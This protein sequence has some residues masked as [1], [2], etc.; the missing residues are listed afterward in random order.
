MKAKDILNKILVELNRK[1]KLAQMTLE[2][3]TVLEAESFDAG[4]EVFI[5]TEEERIPLPVG[6][7]TMEDGSVLKVAE[8]GLIAEVTK[9]EGEAEEVAIEA[10]EIEV[11]APEAIAPAVEEIVQAVVE[12]VAP[13][14]EEVK[15]E[16]KKMKE[17]ME[18]KK[19]EMSKQPA[20]KPIKH[21]PSKPEKDQV[22]LSSNRS[23]ATTFDRVLS[24]LSNR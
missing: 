6:D 1:T 3:G 18:K 13:M 14:I 21:N 4:N 10:E 24:K 5:V 9:K 12:V 11:E 2:N 16:M 20:A 19:E 7:Y 22:Q 23:A 15:E 17:Q 8:E